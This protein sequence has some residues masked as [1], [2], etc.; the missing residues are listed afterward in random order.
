MPY[1]GRAI[2]NTLV[3]CLLSVL[4]AFLVNP[5]AAYALSRYKPPSAYK[6]LLFFMMTVAFSPMVLRIPNFI[7]I[8][9]LGLLN[10]FAALILP[11]VANGYSIFLLKGF[12]D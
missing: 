12:F 6:I 5:L 1:S 11:G 10:T 8:R 3:Y 7:L 9:K 4:A 2:W